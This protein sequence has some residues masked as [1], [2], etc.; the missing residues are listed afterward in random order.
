MNTSMTAAVQ[1]LLVIL[2]GLVVGFKGQSSTI[3]DH[4]IQAAIS[5][6][7]AMDGRIDPK[8]ID[9]KVDNGRA[10]LSG[11]VETLTEKALAE[12]LV[13]SIYGVKAVDN[14]LIVKPAPTKDTAVQ[15][16]VKEAIKTTPALQKSDIQVAVSD[17]VVTLKGAVEKPSQSAAAELAATTAP[18]VVRVVNM[19]KVTQPRPDREI[20]KDIV[21]YLKSSSL[22]NLDDVEYTV[23]DGVVT[24]KGAVDNLS[25]K[26]TIASD[27]EK[28]HGVKTVDVSG[29]TVKSPQQA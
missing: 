27:M 24:L 9:V 4:E 13:A 28:I 11:T 20:E 6:R 18:G 14:H 1:V 12:N 2:L 15:R 3:A 17:G 22:V 8:A 16:A 26:Y 10:I 29:L 23:K 7:L 19:L 5:Q 25:H 21:F